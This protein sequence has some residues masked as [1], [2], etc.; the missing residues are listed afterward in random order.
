MKRIVCWALLSA[1]AVVLG[2]N[3]AALAGSKGV[4]VVVTNYT[5]G[6]PFSP[7]ACVVHDGTFSIYELG[8]PASPALESIAEDAVVSDLQDLVDAEDSAKMLVVGAGPIPPGGTDSVVVEMDKNDLVSCVWML[9]NT[10]DTFSSIT[11][12]ERPRKREVF[13]FHR[14]ALDAGTEVNDEKIENIPG[15]CCGDME[16]DGEDEGGVILGSPGIAGGFDL[17]HA[18]DWRGAVAG[19]IVKRQ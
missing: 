6:Q 10:N 2:L 7:I 8:Q 4:E 3:S 9:V 5:A 19:V 13:H 18:Q 1:A 12:V 16:R 15:P 11:A 14:I 17:G